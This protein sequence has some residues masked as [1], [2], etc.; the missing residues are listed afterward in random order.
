MEKEL[1]CGSDRAFARLAETVQHLKSAPP[2][3][4]EQSPAWLQAAVEG[5]PGGPELDWLLRTPQV[6]V[7]RAGQD[8]AS[9][10]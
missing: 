7:R 8:D 6:S 1:N 9:L 5:D 4:P 3:I 10:H 2:G